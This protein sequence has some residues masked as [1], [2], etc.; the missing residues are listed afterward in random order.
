MLLGW[1]SRGFAFIPAFLG[2]LGDAG[3]EKGRN[4]SSHSAPPERQFGNSLAAS[5]VWGDPNGIPRW[6]HQSPIPWISGIHEVWDEPQPLPRSRGDANPPSHG[7]APTKFFGNHTT[8]NLLL[9]HPFP[10]PTVI[11]GWDRGGSTPSFPKKGL[12]LEGR[13]LGR[14]QECWIF[15]KTD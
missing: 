13:S 1:I 2:A 8:T 5:Q 15:S 9:L 4:S 6:F 7:A 12:T 14:A 3:K 11:P 10:H